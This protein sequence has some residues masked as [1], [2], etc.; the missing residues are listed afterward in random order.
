MKVASPTQQVNKIMTIWNEHLEVAKAFPPLAAAV[1]RAVDMIYSS[2][3][4]GGQLLIAGNGGSEAM[5]S[6]LLRN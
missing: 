5:R 1:S 3:A 2:L 6:I 4:A